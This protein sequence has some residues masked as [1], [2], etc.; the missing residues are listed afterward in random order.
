MV[1]KR[2]KKKSVT[3]DFGPIEK[4]QHGDYQEIL[5]KIAGVK[6]LRNLTHDPLEMYKNR[7][8]ITQ[9]QFEAGETFAQSYR[10]AQLVAVYVQSR[11]NNL[12]SGALTLEAAE[13]V[14]LS[15]QKVRHALAFVGKPLDGVIV[16]VVGDGHHA[17]TWAGVRNSNRQA[18]DG[19]AALRLALDGLCQFYQI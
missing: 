13:I 1:K 6:A 3:S 7:G 10:K 9:L 4:L 11:Y 5:T 18:Q 15:K 14:Q 2:K 16:H 17:G 8:T 12:P 19:V